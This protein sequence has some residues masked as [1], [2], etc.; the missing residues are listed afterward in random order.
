MQMHDA[1]NELLIV[2]IIMSFKI[3]LQKFLLFSFYY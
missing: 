1:L 3:V 2:A